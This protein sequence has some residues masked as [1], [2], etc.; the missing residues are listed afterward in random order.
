MGRA[1]S[2]R[3]V[4]NGTIRRAYCGVAQQ[5]GLGLGEGE[6]HVRE[7]SEGHAADLVG[8]AGGRVE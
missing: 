8:P 4:S 6:E 1:G 3:S 7:D 5:G 2:G